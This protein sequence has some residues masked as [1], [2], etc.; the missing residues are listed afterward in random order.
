MIS[1]RHAYLH[2]LDPDYHWVYVPDW[3]FVN[4]GDQHTRTPAVSVGKGGARSNWCNVRGRTHFSRADAPTCV[5]F[6]LLSSLCHRK[7]RLLSPLT[8]PSPRWFITCSPTDRVTKCQVVQCVCDAHYHQQGLM[9]GQRGQDEA[10]CRPN[11]IEGTALPRIAS[12]RGHL[13]ARTLLMNRRRHSSSAV[14][15]AGHELSLAQD[16]D[17]ASRGRF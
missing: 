3:S 17:S 1:H 10:H 16:R 2:S 14:A 4:K 5:I 15:F 7:E 6:T 13:N 9:R 11:C 12:S 8:R